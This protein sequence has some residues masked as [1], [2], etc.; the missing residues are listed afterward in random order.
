MFYPA[1]YDWLLL[2]R[3]KHYHKDTYYE[4]K[5]TH[6]HTFA[7]DVPLTSPIFPLSPQ[8]SGTQGTSKLA[9]VDTRDMNRMAIYTK[10]D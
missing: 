10:N 8:T 4:S 2:A 6:A 5:L 3:L 9:E 7:N 1:S